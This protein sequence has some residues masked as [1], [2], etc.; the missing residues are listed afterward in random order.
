MYILRTSAILAY[1]A[2]AD[3]DLAAPVQQVLQAGFGGSGQFYS[4]PAVAFGC[5]GITS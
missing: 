2:P 5:T 3:V 4:S 1:I